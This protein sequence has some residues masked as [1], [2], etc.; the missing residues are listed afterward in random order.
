VIALIP[1]PVP[2]PMDLTTED[3]PPPQRVTR[4]STERAGR[5]DSQ[6]LK[7]PKRRRKAMAMR[8]K[9]FVWSSTMTTSTA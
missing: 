7:M 6:I 3:S 1:V 8:T 9:R 5:E 4:S 2:E